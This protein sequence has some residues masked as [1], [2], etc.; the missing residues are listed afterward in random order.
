[1]KTWRIIILILA[2][3]AVILLLPRSPRGKSP[4]LALQFRSM[5]PR[6]RRPS[7]ERWKR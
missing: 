6:P 2:A 4:E 5:I 1:M 7:K 3:V